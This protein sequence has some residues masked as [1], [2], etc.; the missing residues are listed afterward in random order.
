MACS[1]GLKQE[2]GTYA[3]VTSAY[4]S[5]FTAN[6]TVLHPRRSWKADGS[7]ILPVSAVLASSC[8]GICSKMHGA[9]EPYKLTFARHAISCLAIFDFKATCALPKLRNWPPVEFTSC[10]CIA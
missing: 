9:S 5:L 2:L 10:E 7:S 1:V 8:L 3:G 4:N 6:C